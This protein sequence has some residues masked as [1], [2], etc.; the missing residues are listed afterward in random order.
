MSTAFS[1]TTGF[2]RGEVES[3]LFDRFDVDFY[4]AASKRVENWFPDVTGALERRPGFKP[5]GNTTQPFGDVSFLVPEYPEEIDPSVDCGQFFMRTFVF[6]GTT[7]LL[8]FRQVCELGWRTVTITCERLNGNDELS[9]EFEDIYL[10]HYSND[11]QNLVDA[12]NSAGKDIPPDSFDGNTPD[13][14]SDNLARN[15]CLAQVGPA[16]FI[17]S[18][19][20]P[21]YRVFVS[22][23]KSANVEKVQ[24]FQELIGTVEI[25][26]GKKKWKGEDTLFEDQLS[27]G[28]SFFFKGD[29]YTVD[30]ITSQTEMTSNEKFTT[31]TFS[32]AG[33][34]IVKKT[35]VFDTDWPR[36]CAFYKGR[37]T[38]FSTRTKPVGFFASQSNDPFVIIPG[39]VYDDAP[40]EVELLTEG[41]ESFRWVSADARILLGGEQ[42]E[43]IIDTLSDQPLTPTDFSFFRVA[44]NGGASIQPFSS[45][46]STVFVNRGGNR[47]QSVQ[48]NDQRAGFVGQDLSLLAPHLFQNRI[49]DLTFRPGTRNDRAPRIFALTEAQELRSCTFAEQEQ[50]VAWNRMSLADGYEFRAIA[51]SPDDMYALVRTPTNQFVLTVLDVRNDEFYQ[52]DFEL[53]YNVSGGVITDLNT[54]H[55]NST[56]VVLDGSRFV[57]FFKTDDSG[58]LDLGDSEIDGQVIVGVTYASVLQM[59]PVVTDNR[60]RGESLNQKHRLLRVIVSVEEAYQLAV[61]DRQFFGTVAQNEE[62]GFAKRQGSFEQRFLGWTERP[63]TELSVTS[64]YRAKL[65]SVTREVQ[66]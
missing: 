27:V 6:R 64:L 46:A 18:P 8:I 4:R 66:I 37:L 29:E 17:T 30:S 36:L 9:N 32:I 48:F 43:Y 10:V 62:T 57:G 55:Q 56:V 11:S 60:G 7:Y 24:F 41:A 40:I 50:V 34:R 3:S 13:E 21:P 53:Q 31:E 35:D 44:N 61:N 65:R 42:A 39:S 2:T 16:V 19:L 33:E 54:I 14:F 58:S 22:P 28:D 26:A 47:V 12:L 38:L 5:V 15:V 51:T 52:I 23:D 45:D 1:H 25:E 63:E 59:L 49:N 20:F